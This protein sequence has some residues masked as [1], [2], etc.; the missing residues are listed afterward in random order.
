MILYWEHCK[1]QIKKVVNYRIANATTLFDRSHK[2]TY[3]R[4]GS[5]FDTETSIIHLG[6]YKTAYCYH[7][8]LSLDDLTIG[9]RTLDTMQEFFEFLQLTIP[10]GTLLLCLVANLGYDYQFCK[11]RWFTMGLSDLFAKEKRNPLRFE[12][13]HKIEMREVLGLFGNNL[14]QIAKNYSSVPKLIGDLDYSKVRLSHTK[15]TNKEKAYCENDVQILSQLGNYIFSHYF[16]RNPS[17]PMTSTGII[18]AKVKKRMGNRLKF[19][20]ERI[21]S[22][23]PDEETY[24]YF[25][26]YLF[27]GGLCGTNARYMGK[28]LHNVVCADYTSDYPGV[29]NHYEFPDG[30]I[31][32]CEPDEFMKNR[33]PY[34]ALIRFDGFVSRSTHSLMSTHK[35]LD[36]NRRKLE[37]DPTYYAIDNGRI[38]YAKSV[39]Y[40][41]NDVEY[42]ALENAYKWKDKKILKCW[43][44]EKYR[45]LPFWLLDTLNEE[46]LKKEELKSTGKSETLE[47]K[48]SK[49][50]VNGTFGMT[51][52]A[53]FF[54]EL[55]FDGWNIEP[56][57]YEDS[58]EIYKKPYAEAIKSLFLNP[59]WGFW[60]T[61][62]ARSLLF[63]IISKFPKPIVQ[64]DTD[65]IYYIKEHPDTQALEE[66]I[67]NY[68]NRIYNLNEALFDSNEHYRTLGAWEVEKPYRRFKG[69]GSKRYM[70]EK[71]DKGEWKI[72]TTVAGARKGTIEEQWKFEVQEGLFDGDI[73]DFFEDG[74]VVAS[75]RSGKLASRYVE[76]YEDGNGLSS[77]IT[78]VNYRDYNGR[79][80]E[81]ILECAV[82]L[83]PVDYRLG[84]DE[85]HAEFVLEMQSLFRNSPR[86]SEISKMYKE[87][88][89]GKD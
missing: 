61:S 48:D 8:A 42:K 71:F 55:I 28:V 25:R 19:E 39:T 20:K 77:P 57:T 38:Y 13:G 34:I 54:E 7:W 87:V 78:V 47:Y 49:A 59:F 86:N 4:L 37:T 23:M 73:F 79:E 67:V 29:M 62:Y 82:V 43:S 89:Y 56:R 70:Y 15:L 72:K 36:F 41:V 81:I 53:L 66:F 22:I 51:C 24:F 10:D 2:R 27:K 6:G 18:R 21:Q 32:E 52:T 83:E 30:R 33:L 84:I 12:I 85:K 76:F 50:I 58:D 65:S 16:G 11:R 31:T 5:G 68:N 14:N 74:L 26:Q 44:F 35:A 17:L 75:S 46:Y 63:E 1:D 9:G 45:R 80:E 88:F 64:Y 3:L 69:L 40:L 60:I